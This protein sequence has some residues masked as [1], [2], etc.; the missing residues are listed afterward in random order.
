MMSLNFS[1]S[2]ISTPTSEIS[3]RLTCP[4]NIKFKPDGARSHTFRD[5]GSAAKPR[6]PWRR[7]LNYSTVTAHH[8]V[9]IVVGAAKIICSGPMGCQKDVFRLTRLHHNLCA[10]MIE[11]IGI[12][13]I[14]GSE[15]RR[16]RKLVGFPAVILEV[17]PIMDIVH[18]R[19]MIWDEPVVDHGEVYRLRLRA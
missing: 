13:D 10:V 18:K 8:A 3:R 14:G 7:L 6:R 2:K 12:V 19:Q 11:R 4:T 15:E 9:P 17:Q 5:Q 1:I 16:R